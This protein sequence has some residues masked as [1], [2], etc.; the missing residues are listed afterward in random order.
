VERHLDSAGLAP[1]SSRRYWRWTF[2]GVGAKSL[3]Q[4]P[5]GS[6]SSPRT[7]RTIDSAPDR[8]QSAS[9]FPQATAGSTR[10]PTVD[11]DRPAGSRWYRTFVAPKAVADED[12]TT[13]SPRPERT[14]TQ[15]DVEAGHSSKSG[16]APVVGPGSSVQSTDRH[17]P[18]AA[19]LL[20]PARSR[21]TNRDTRVS[22]RAQ[23]DPKTP[24]R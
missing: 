6:R 11:L 21:R 2:W 16:T 20:P 7:R 9:R 15:L 12:G 18:T 13:C 1:T 24:N 19:L 17:F 4:I 8:K 23:S 22:P 5:G 10:G 3:G 14:R